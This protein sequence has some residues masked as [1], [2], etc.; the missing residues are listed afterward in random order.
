M[1]R[2]RTF[3][4]SAEDSDRF[5]LIAF[6]TSFKRLSIVSHGDAGALGAVGEPEDGGGDG[7]AFMFEV[8]V[9][10]E[11]GELLVLFAMVVML[12]CTLLRLRAWGG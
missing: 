9:A 8:L 1:R 2:D 10:R 6:L 5:S 11:V 4:P 3:D 12:F 7:C